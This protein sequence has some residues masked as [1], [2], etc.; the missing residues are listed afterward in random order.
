MQFSDS[1]DAIEMAGAESGGFDSNC[2]TLTRYVLA[3]QKKVPDATGDLT[4]LL[5]SIQTAVKT[6]SSA[7]R[8]AGIVQL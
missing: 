2:M 4:Q 5:V 7:V 1:C 8:K 3:N 6:V